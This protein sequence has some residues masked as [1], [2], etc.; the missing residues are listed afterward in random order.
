MTHSDQLDSSDSLPLRHASSVRLSSPPPRH[1]F[2]RL[3]QPVQ[4]FRT[5]Y[6]LPMFG[7]YGAMTRDQG[8]F[9]VTTVRTGVA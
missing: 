3:Y 2:R 9:G 1:L 4:H 5:F 7:I 6:L 8:D